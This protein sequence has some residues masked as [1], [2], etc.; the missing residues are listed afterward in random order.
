MFFGFNDQDLGF[1][2]NTINDLPDIKNVKW[3]HSV[4]TKNKLWGRFGKKLDFFYID[5]PDIGLTTF[6]PRTKSL[7]FFNTKN[8][9]TFQVQSFFKHHLAPLLLSL[10]GEIILHCGAVEIDQ[11]AY[12]FIGD[13]GVGKSTLSLQLLNLR[14]KV[15]G[16]DAFRVSKS[17]FKYSLFSGTGTLRVNKDLPQHLIE[18]FTISNSY[19]N[20]L[21]INLDTFSQNKAIEIASLFFIKNYQEFKISK[22]CKIEVFPYL[23]ANSFRLDTQNQQLL[24]LELKALNDLL[25]HLP[26]YFLYWPQDFSK[27]KQNTERFLDYINSF[28]L[29]NN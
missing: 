7:N 13:Q 9:P 12:L 22:A 28:L 21:I 8:W 29:D 25:S 5:F 2:L 6:E 24:K 14:Q 3:Y 11:K 4:K 16:D 26:C 15:L 27:L 18:N 1:K 23:L 10:S 20:K 19:F 17:E